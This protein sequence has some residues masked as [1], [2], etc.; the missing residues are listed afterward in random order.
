MPNCGGIVILNAVKNTGEDVEH[1]SSRRIPI[2]FA[3][4][5]KADDEI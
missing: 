1:A 2:R 4:G 3:H 5:D